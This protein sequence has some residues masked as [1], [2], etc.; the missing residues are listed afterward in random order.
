MSGEN[1]KIRGGS[2]GLAAMIKMQQGMESGETSSP[3]VPE[4]SSLS[5]DIPVKVTPPVSS[6]TSPTENIQQLQDNNVD[7]TS[8]IKPSGANRRT[9]VLQSLSA[10]TTPRCVICTKSVYKME[11]I[12]AVNKI[13]HK[14][15]FTCGGTVKNGCGRVLNLNNYLDH[16]NQPY[17]NACYSKLYRPKGFGNNLSTD[18][19]K[20]GEAEVQNAKE[21]LENLSIDQSKSQSVTEMPS[22]SLESKMDESVPPTKSIP[23]A[24]VAPQIATSCES[25]STETKAATKAS[26]AT[27]QPPVLS[28]QSLNSHVA[29]NV[30]I[31]REACYVGD[32]NEVDESEWE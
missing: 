10:A 9:S 18:Y 15:C 26:S 30:K 6:E 25:S 2:R 24:V 7:T 23:P 17:C 3:A 12:Q 5:S 21:A 4:Q 20:T 16:D 32:G 28:S 11:E 22:S 31:Q 8:N 27:W 13:W 1:I 19:G 14:S 29:G